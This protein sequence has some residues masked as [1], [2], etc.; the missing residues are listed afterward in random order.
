M[1][2]NSLESDE[3]HLCHEWYRGKRAFFPNREVLTINLR[4]RTTRCKNAINCAAEWHSLYGISAQFMAFRRTPRIF[5]FY[6]LPPENMAVCWT[7]KTD[8][9]RMFNFSSQFKMK[10]LCP[11]SPNLVAVYAMGSLNKINEQDSPMN[12]FSQKRTSQ[13]RPFFDNLKEIKVQE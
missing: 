4:G 1:N 7:L 11:F 12:L 9:N 6:G 3:R 5:A 2:L 10:S 8:T 13:I